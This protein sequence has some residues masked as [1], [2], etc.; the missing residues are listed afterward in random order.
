MSVVTPTSPLTRSLEARSWYED[1]AGAWSRQPPLEGTQRADVAVVGA[2]LTGLTAALELKARGFDV[3]VLEARQ[4]AWGASGRSG[5]QVIFGYGCE[6]AKL[7]RLVGAEEARR[8]FDWSLEGVKLIGDR[9]RAHA[10]DCD[11][12]AGHA[13]AAIK[14]RQVDELKA[15]QADLEQHCGYTGMQLHEGA[16]AR[17]LVAS[18]RYRALLVDPRSGHLHPLKYTRGLAHAALEAGV[19][20]HEGTA[21]TAIEDG[22]EV[23][24]RSATGAQVRAPFA[25]LAGNAWLGRLQ[26]ALE[27]RIMPVGTYI[28]ATEPLGAERAQALICQAIAVADINFVLDYF[29]LSAD[30]RL[31]FGGRVSYSGVDPPALATRLRHRMLQVFPS[32]QHTA[33]SHVWGGLVDITMNRAPDFGRIGSHIYYAQGFSGHGIAATGLAGRVLAEAIAGQ[34]GRLDVFSRIPHRAFPGGP[35]LRTPMLML[36]MLAFRLRDAW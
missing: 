1:S 16:A 33:F 7:R 24:L 5:G 6:Q 21:I 26:P 30:H 10:I 4:V 11:Y 15:W 27:R 17:A 32:L 2:G 3:V 29:R 36:A 23:L 20:L 22:T 14:P 8:L 13:H 31:L 9:C 34:T 35:W 25:V 28:A 18:E 19:R 12:V